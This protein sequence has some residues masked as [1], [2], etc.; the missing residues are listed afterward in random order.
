MSK[1]TL[2]GHFM[3]KN[4]LKKVD[5]L[6]TFRWIFNRILIGLQFDNS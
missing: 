3:L 6:V 4:P 1:S 2:L 5:F